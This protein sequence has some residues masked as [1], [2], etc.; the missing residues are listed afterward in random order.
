MTI[1]IASA[2]AKQPFEYYNAR[3]SDNAAFSGIMFDILPSLFGLIGLN[4]TDY[5]I[6]RAS[7]HSS[8]YLLPSNTWT[9]MTPSLASPLSPC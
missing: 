5:S 4:A 9:G 7:D 2:V 3:R 1:R 6:Y 8:G